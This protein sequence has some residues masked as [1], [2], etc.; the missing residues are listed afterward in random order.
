MTDQDN[1]PAVPESLRQ[2]A[3]ALARE[4]AARRPEDS[5]ALSPEK[6]QKTLH[7]LQVHQIELEMQ[8]EELRTAQTQIE[9]GRARYYDL[10]NLAPVGYC[11][12]SEQGLILE[13]NLTAAT[14]LGTTRDQLAKQP[15]TR[16]IFKED[17]DIYYLHRKQSE[18]QEC[19]LRLVKPNGARFWVHLTTTTAQA[20]DDAP[21]Y[22]VVLSDITERKRAEEKLIEQRDFAESL[23][24]T[25]QSIILVLDTQGR[26]VQF[27]S[28]M[29]ELV[30]YELDEVKGQDWFETFIRL[31]N[32]NL[33][34]SVFQD[35][36]GDIQPS[37]NVNSIIAKDGR[38]ILVEWSN[39]TLKDKDG[40]TVG[41]LAIGQDITEKRNYQQA[42]LR[43]SQLS[44]L[45]EV[46][47]GVAHEINNPING[48]INYAQLMIN[49]NNENDQS[50][51]IL[52]RII[53][54]GN[55]ISTI[56]KNLLNF[57]SKDRN[58]FSSLDIADI[59]TE[60][61][62]LQTQ[63]LKKDGINVDLRVPSDL[64]KIYGNRMQLEQVVLNLLSNA[65]HALHKKY[66]QPCNEKC[67]VIEAAPSHDINGGCVQL[68][69]TDFGCGIPKDHLEKI[70]NPF[71]TTKEAGVGTGL[72]MSI[73]HEILE[74][75]GAAISI[76]SQV[77]KYTTVKI[78]FPAQSQE[79]SN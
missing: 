11:T 44:A 6:I 20:E 27:N 15:I 63:L 13:A 23:I 53:R 61:I 4:R 8:N 62:N 41:V 10:Y 2:K 73:S 38:S 47:A 16:F 56:V 58:A 3:E 54:E 40:L 37:D 65:R 39:K 12:L 29:E 36:L 50:N 34:K 76:D 43:S 52:V 22:R 9:A 42:Q 55:R 69:I 71:F 72:G 32:G 26:I 31:D 7:E 60:P 78:T 67:I 24:E 35:T 21:V 79:T 59:V 66:P 51:Q 18:V 57:A 1:R 25:A 19:E 17:Q 64:P 28:Y 33:V 14:L 49:R 68:S 74:K 5:A 77:N 70:F 75:H 30:G 46:A 45:G 48:V